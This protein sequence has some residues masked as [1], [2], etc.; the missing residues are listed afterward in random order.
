M[1]AESGAQNAT[2]EVAQSLAEFVQVWKSEPTFSF[3]IISPMFEREQRL[4]ALL[5]VAEALNLNVIAKRFLEVVFK[6]DRVTILPEIIQAYQELAEKQ[7]GIV[8]VQIQ[9]A[10]NVEDHERSEIEQRLKTKIP[11]NLVFEWGIDPGLLGGMVVLYEGKILDTSLV[12]RLN[13]LA[14]EL[15]A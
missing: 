3:H 7:A 5:A 11:G 14:E 1:L 10:R 6:R 9:T 13:Q 12:S 15:Q 2:L 4:N 8:H